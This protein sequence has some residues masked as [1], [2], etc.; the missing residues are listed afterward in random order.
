MPEGWGGEGAEAEELTQ[1]KWAPIVL[2]RPTAQQ[3]LGRLE[4]VLPRPSP[5]P[6]LE[7]MWSLGTA[8]PHPSRSLWERLG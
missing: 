8:A 3:G 2:A 4:V 6:I 1:P 5:R 7:E